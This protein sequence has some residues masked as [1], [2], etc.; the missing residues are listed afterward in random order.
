MKNFFALAAILIVSNLTYSQD[1][2]EKISEKASFVFAINGDITM[3]KVTNRDIDNSNLF[4]ELLDEFFRRRVPVVNLEGFGVDYDQTMYFAYEN[5]T[6]VN[7]YYFTY[8]IKDLESFEK[9]VKEKIEYEDFQTKDGLNFI[10][11]YYDSRLIWN[12][13]TAMLLISDYVGRQYSEYNYWY[14]NDYYYEEAT[15]MTEAVEYSDLENMTQEEWEAYMNEEKEK[16]AKIDE[17]NRLA[18]EKKEKER[19]EKEAKKREYVDDKMLERA[20]T[21]F[22]DDLKKSGKNFKGD[23]NPQAD[24]S[25]W[26]DNHV[27]F[28]DLFWYGRYMGYY[29]P[30]GSI[31]NM[32]NFFNGELT[33]DLFLNETNIQIK[34]EMTYHGGLAEAFGKIYSKKIDKQFTKYLSNS[35]LGFA[36][37]AFDTEEMLNAYPDIIKN[38]MLRYDTSYADE[39]SL[40][41]DIFSLVIDEE[42]V[43][44]AITGDAVF[45]LNEVSNKEVEYY[46]YDYDENYNYERKLKTKIEL[47]PDF[48]FLIGSNEDQIIN[49]L[50]KIGLKHNGLEKAGNGYKMIDK[51]ND[52]PFDLYFA[53]DE[54][55]FI[56]TTSKKQLAQFM[57]GGSGEKLDATKNKLITKNSG[58]MFLDVPTLLGQL[59]SSDDIR[60]SDRR[61]FTAMQK[62]LQE[63]TAKFYNKGGTTFI[64]AS[65]AVPS[66][67]ENGALYLLH[68][69]DH[70]IEAERN[71]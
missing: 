39:Y 61:M 31:F 38:M 32:G 11:Y 62:D 19:E 40:F 34:S 57:N 70:M 36:S 9:V 51:W 17:K 26:Y 48:S 69:I 8:R 66:A 20:Q 13:N 35:D 21:F 58:A 33:A 68:F 71:R 37:F 30:Y 1:L 2:K 4:K 41:A 5:D 14:D 23:I 67:E 18:R 22:S 63:M 65:T 53:Y 52:F 29:N 46:S 49:K 54:S 15:D 24:A 45:I 60:G 43:A 10:S 50:F 56:T 27:S 42:N 28:F 12:N 44:N 64:E 55:I 16:Q 7:M 25:L 59:L 6:D 47:L 3:Q